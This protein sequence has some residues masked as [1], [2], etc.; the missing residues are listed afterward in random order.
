MGAKLCLL[1]NNKQKTTR[2]KL[3]A[4]RKEECNLDNKYAQEF[5]VTFG[6]K[7]QKAVTS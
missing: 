5:D 7:P 6:T 1:N 2:H 3:L 4:L